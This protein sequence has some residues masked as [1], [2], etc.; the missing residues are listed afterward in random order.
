MLFISLVLAAAHDTSLFLSLNSTSEFKCHTDL[1]CQLNGICEVSTNTCKCDAAWV[2]SNCGSLNLIS[3]GSYAYAPPKSSAWGG[4]PPVKDPESGKYV[5]FVTQI[6]N[7]CGLSEWQHMSTIVRAT[8]TSPEGPY[9]EEELVVPT[10]AHN[11]YYVQDPASKTHLIYHIGGGDN[12]ESKT[13]P[14]LHNCSNGTTPRTATGEA[15]GAA[16]DTVYSSQPYLHASTSLQGPFTRVNF[17]L[18]PGHTAVGW[19][20]DNP[21]PFI[22][23]NGTVLM[24][25]RKY[26]HTRATKHE[27]PHDTIWLVRAD[28]Y[29]GPYTLVFDRPVFTD[30]NFNEEDPCI[31]RDARGH[32][33]ALF[34]FTKGHAWSE[35][36]LAWHWGGGVPAWDFQIRLDNGTIE[37]LHDTERPRVY[38]NPATKQPE[39]FFVASG[40]SRQPSHPGDPK[41]FLA[42]QRIN[43]H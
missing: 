35:D 6:A 5:L 42:V 17:S 4:G 22:F 30:E 38:I 32:F 29:K 41:S 18:P 23:D 40:G 13:N 9:V 11:A 10:Q 37:T 15:L 33:H 43:T 36:G 3:P 27:E 7:N 16:D 1:D 39:L 2:G 25:T 34:H 31:W 21:A 20:N 26:N 14:F 8:A 12:P 28:S 19:G 24:L